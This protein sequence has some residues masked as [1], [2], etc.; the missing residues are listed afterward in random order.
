MAEI[1]ASIGFFSALILGFVLMVLGLI[2][3][4]PLAWALGSTDLILPKAIE[5]MRYIL[6]GSP[7]MVASLVLNNQLTFSRFSFFLNDRYYKWCSF[8]YSS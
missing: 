4:E 8:K 6:I 2:F 7:Y 5:Y 3:I 1:M